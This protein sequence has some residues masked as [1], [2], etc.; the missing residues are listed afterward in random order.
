ML[1]QSQILWMEEWNISTINKTISWY[2]S[3]HPLLPTEN[4]SA[5]VHCMSTIH[6]YM[7][8]ESA[9]LLQA[10]IGSLSSVTASQVSLPLTESYYYL[11]EKMDSL[12]SGCCSNRR[13]SCSLDLPYVGPLSLRHF[14]EHFCCIFKEKSNK[15][16]KETQDLK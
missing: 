16:K 6:Y 13:R 3:D 14:V 15:V 9:T 4:I 5:I 1:Q 2:L 11:L 7:L 10:G 8:V 12:L